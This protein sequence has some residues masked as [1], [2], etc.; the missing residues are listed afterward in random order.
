MKVQQLLVT[1]SLVATAL[2]APSGPLAAY[3]VPSYDAAPIYRPV[4][5]YNE[6][7][8]YVFDYAV[9]DSL[10]NDYGHQESRD[11]Y[12]TK[13]SYYVQL[14]DGRLQHVNYYVNGDSGFVAEVTYSGEAQYPAYS[15]APAYR[16]APVYTPA[17]AYTPAPHY[18]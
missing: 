7:P 12:D 17:P 5:A 10:G 3:S 18:G 4:P 14:P 11:G 8:R 13:G 1:L 9:R 2:A 15:P 16:P 6:V